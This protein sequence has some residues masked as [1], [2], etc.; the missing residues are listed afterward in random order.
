LR[1]NK[2]VFQEACQ[3]ISALF[4]PEG[5]TSHSAYEPSWVPGNQQ[6]ELYL[7]RRDL[8]RH[9]DQLQLVFAPAD[10]TFR[11][12]VWRSVN[13]FGIT[14]ISGIPRAAAWTERWLPAPVTEYLLL[15]GSR[16]WPVSERTGFGY[17]PRDME[18]PRALAA[19]ITRAIG[20]NAP[21]LLKALRGEYRGR[22]VQVRDYAILRP[23][24]RRG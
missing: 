3:G 16:W 9:V 5:F 23:G 17:R 20:R 11:L 21:Y 2:Q 22:F 24:D 8:S 7:I 10:R 1:P 15:S 14:D 18:E 6:Y 19:R 4:E 13:S 12:S